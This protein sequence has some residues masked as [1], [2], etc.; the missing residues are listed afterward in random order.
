MRIATLLLT[1]LLTAC[2]L[3]FKTNSRPGEPVAVNSFFE[4]QVLYHLAF[5][6]HAYIELEELYELD[7][8]TTHALQNNLLPAQHVELV[9]K[10]HH[11]LQSYLI[12]LLTL[13]PTDSNGIIKTEMSSLLLQQLRHQNPEQIDLTRP[14]HAAYQQLRLG[15][16]ATTNSAPEDIQSLFKEFLATMLLMT[17]QA[18]H[19]YEKVFAF[20]TVSLAEL[21]RTA[22]HKDCHTLGGAETVEVT[23]TIDLEMATK[24]V[25]KNIHHL[26]K[27]ITDMHQLDGIRA[28][29]GGDIDFYEQQLSEYHQRYEFVLMKAAQQSVLPIFFTDIF[30]KR[31]GDIHLRNWEEWLSS[32]KMLTDVTL[33]TVSQAIVELKQE[34]IA[35]WATIKKLQQSQRPM[36]E[37]DIYK[38]LSSNEVAV[39]RLLMQSPEYAAVVNF[40][41]HKYEHRV[42]NKKWQKII[43]GALSTIGISTLLIF[44]GSLTPLLPM[45]A[46]L[47][48]A[49]LVSAAANFGW[50]SLN[51]NDSLVIRGHHLR[52]ERSLLTGTSQRISDNLELLRQFEAARKNAI[53]SGAISLSMTAASYNLIL[54]SLNSSSRPFLSSYIHNLFVTKPQTSDYTDIFIDP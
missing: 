14:N 21:C 35:R 53:L 6:Q 18:M 52:L 45:N 9:Q 25:N 16:M 7:R 28:I 46:V 34:I 2:I 10:W 13:Q 38:W 8:K 26:N 4:L 11:K 41:I 31:S 42:D 54:K 24:M 3:E 37:K 27:I 23:K 50:V 29:T 43:K 36:K 20:E 22:K 32:N 39:A 19:R 48:K 47:S 51:I 49:V 40:L 33:T 44:V 5:E 12:F 15:V 30:T 17:E 1:L